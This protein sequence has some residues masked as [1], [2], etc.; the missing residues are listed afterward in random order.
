M[1]PGWGH[2]EAYGIARFPHDRV[3]MLG[4][5]TSKTTTAG[6]GGAAMLLP[7]IP[8]Y[9]EFEARFLAGRGIG[10]YGSAQLPGRHDR[11]RWRAPIRSA[12]SWAWAG[13]TAHPT[14]SVDIYAYGGTE[15]VGRRYYDEDKKAYGYGNPLYPDG[16]LR[17]RT[18]LVI[19]LRGQHLR[20]CSGHRRRVVAVREGAVRD[21]AGRAAILLH[22]PVFLFWCRA[23]AED[24]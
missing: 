13:L 14:K 5:G 16:D 20:R 22:A 4:D 2:F 17:G 9:L 6:G 8:G 3:S 19:R 10:R 7:I 24:G 21:D 23:Y 1:D 18:R 15:Q 12:K 11:R